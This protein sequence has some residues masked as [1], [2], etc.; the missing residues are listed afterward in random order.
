V[1]EFTETVVEE[2]VMQYEEVTIFSHL[3]NIKR[4]KEYRPF[5]FLEKISL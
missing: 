5:A 2:E 1:K 4:M 3:H